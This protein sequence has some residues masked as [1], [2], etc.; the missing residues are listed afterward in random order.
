M[1]T[2]PG[3]TKACFLLLSFSRPSLKLKLCFWR[4]KFF[5]LYRG[6]DSKEECFS[7]HVS[8]FCYMITFLLDSSIFW[9]RRWKYVFLAIYPPALCLSLR[10]HQDMRGPT[11]PRAGDLKKL[12]APLQTAFLCPRPC[13]RAASAFSLSLPIPLSPS[14]RLV[15]LPL[16]WD[17]AGPRTLACFS[18]SIVLI[19]NWQRSRK[20]FPN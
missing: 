17:M 3:F 4:F 12:A 13:Q 11:L 7:T 20:Y 8:S 16:C 19:W 2:S 14:L 5:F 18:K 1:F 15:C 9:R 6:F 10:F